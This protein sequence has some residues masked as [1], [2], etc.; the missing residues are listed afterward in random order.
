MSDGAA[1]MST[2]T[3]KS[4]AD[5]LKSIKGKPVLVKTNSGVDYKGTGIAAA[6]LPLFNTAA[7]RFARHAAA[8]CHSA[9]TP[10]DQG[11]VHCSMQRRD[12]G[13]LRW[14]H[15]HRDGANRGAAG[16]RFDATLTAA[17]CHRLQLSTVL[18]QRP[19]PSSLDSGAL[20]T[21]SVDESEKRKLDVSCSC[22]RA[23]PE[24]LQVQNA[25]S[26]EE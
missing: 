20:L 13:L 21:G 10:I 18:Q 3:A 25:F 5:F 26:H 19:M 1:A 8:Y 6:C 11:V 15:E 9:L 4:P 24:R 22:V 16:L 23:M 17:G 14:L 7:T 12:T 2:G